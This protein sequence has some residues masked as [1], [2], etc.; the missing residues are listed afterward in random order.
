[1]IYDSRLRKLVTLAYYDGRM[2]LIKS[3]YKAF[4]DGSF[5]LVW[6]QVQGDY[7]L[8]SPDTLK[9]LNN[10]IGKEYQMKIHSNKKWELIELEELL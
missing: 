10:E 4:K 5:K 6:A 7:I 9:W 3:L 8:L 1:M 2:K